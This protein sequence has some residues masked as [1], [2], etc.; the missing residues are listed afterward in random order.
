MSANKWTELGISF[1][2]I[3]KDD[4]LQVEEFLAKH[5]Y[6]DEPIF[7]STK[8]AEGTGILQKYLT[9]LIRHYSTLPC[10]KDATSLM[11]VDKN[12][13]ILGVR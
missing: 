1:K 3:T 11:A 6:T 9:H 8:L 2:A 4:I 12:G 13:N 10:F 7:R 5:F